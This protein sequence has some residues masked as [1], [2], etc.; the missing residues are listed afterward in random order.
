MS[1]WALKDVSGAGA[2]FSFNIFFNNS[3]NLVK[4]FG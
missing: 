1:K 3:A 2:S 4:P